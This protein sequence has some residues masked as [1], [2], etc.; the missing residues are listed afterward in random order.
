MLQ[1]P[2]PEQHQLSES[3]RNLGII[4]PLTVRKLGYDKYQLISGERRLR[5]S[6]LLKIKLIPAYIRIAKDQQMLEMALVENIQRQDLNP[7]EI[8]LSFQRLI[9]E[10]NLTQEACGE[11]L[12][13]NR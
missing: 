11:R 2:N 1:F 10:C 4:Q 9:K 6:K 7:I 8:A 13:K 3:I 12:G 5:A